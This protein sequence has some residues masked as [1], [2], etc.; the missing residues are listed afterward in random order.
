M[1]FYLRL[2]IRTFFLPFQENLLQFANRKIFEKSKMTAK[3]A[4]KE[5]TKLLISNHFENQGD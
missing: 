5:R 4:D 3:I 2:F 1:S